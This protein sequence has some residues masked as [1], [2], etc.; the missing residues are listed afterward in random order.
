MRCRQVSATVSSQLTGNKQI[1]RQPRKKGYNNTS[2][3][4]LIR[5]IP[6]LDVV[7]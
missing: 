7:A 2:K 4:Q 6:E 5:E 1:D 3:V